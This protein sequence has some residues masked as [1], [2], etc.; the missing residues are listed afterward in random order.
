MCVNVRNGAD[1]GGEEV[2]FGHLWRYYTELFGYYYDDISLTE[3]TCSSISIEQEKEFQ[4]I[5]LK[6]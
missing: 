6:E 2:E 1:M 4:F 5:K 3:A